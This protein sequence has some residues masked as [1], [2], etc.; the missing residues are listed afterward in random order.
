MSGQLTLLQGRTQPKKEAITLRPYQQA[1]IEA[2]YQSWQNGHRRVML[3]LPTGGGKTVIFSSIATD[4]LK[5]GQ[6]VLVVAHKKELITQARAKLEAI[7]GLPAGV[8]KAGFPFEPEYDIQVASIQTL[9][10]RKKVRPDAGLLIFDEAHHCSARS[11]KALMEEYPQSL[12]LGVTATPIREDGQGFKSVFDDLITSPP[13]RWFINQGYLCD[14]KYIG[15]ASKVSTK[16][17]KKS[18]GD[19]STSQLAKQAADING[20]VV[21]TWRQYADGLQTIVFCVDVA[22]SKQVCQKFVEAGIPAEHLDGTTPDA[23]RD[24]IIERYKRGETLVLTNCGIFSEGF[25]VPRIECVQII[26]PTASL[27]VYLQQ[28]GRGLRPAPGKEKCI[29]IDHTRNYIEHGLPDED[30]EWSLDCIPPKDPRFCQQCP[31][32][33]HVFKPLH[34]ELKYPIKTVMMRDGLVE[35]YRAICPN[36]GEKIQFTQGQG[37]GAEPRELTFDEQQELIEFDLSIYP[38]NQAIID[39]LLAVQKGRGF[40]KGWVYYRLLEH[41]LAPNF[42]LGDWRLF[43]Q[44]LGYKS[45]WGF[46][47]YKQVQGVN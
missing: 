35:I 9:T 3:Q 16:G 27:A 7:S 8:I 4:A 1:A 5:N 40:K 17:I 47:Q 25:D 11:Y 43:A 20:D 33:E 15:A 24:A 34:H 13:V 23:E 18:R 44:K 19:Y 36:C 26:R 42:S 12:I 22:H 29:I 45:G 14:F 46:I 6:G 2:V 28:V 41:E 10:S 38:E 37:G 39:D 31:T 30:R 21:P 32:C